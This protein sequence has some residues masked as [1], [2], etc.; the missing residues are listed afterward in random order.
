[1]TR[2]SPPAA[3][4]PATHLY[5]F[6]RSLFSAACVTSPAPHRGKGEHRADSRGRSSN[7]NQSTGPSPGLAVQVRCALWCCSCDRTGRS[8]TEVTHGDTGTWRQGTG[9]RQGDTLRRTESQ[10]EARHVPKGRRVVRVDC[11]RD[12]AD[13]HQSRNRATPYKL[14]IGNKSQ[15]SEPGQKQISPTRGRPETSEDNQW[16]KNW[17][18]N[19]SQAV[20]YVSTARN[21][22]RGSL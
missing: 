12:G 3:P 7:Q 10:P 21:E 22:V 4:T 1:M 11:S 2:T 15:K 9:Q 8:R 5:L 17:N 18:S 20:R 14:Q 19:A 13:R 6:P 16:G